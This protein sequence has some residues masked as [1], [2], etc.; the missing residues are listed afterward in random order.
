MF[1]CLFVCLSDSSFVGL[2]VCVF[3]LLCVAVCSHVLM[4]VFVGMFA[5]LCVVA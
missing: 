3:R 4:Y 5:W 2:L 1:D